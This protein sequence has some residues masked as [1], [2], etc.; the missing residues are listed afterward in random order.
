MEP[1]QNTNM[2][3]TTSASIVASVPTESSTS[4]STPN[5]LAESS[6]S[7][8]DIVF[9]DKPKKSHGML[10]GMVLLAILAIGGIG[11]GVWEMMDGNSQVAKKDEQIAD[12]RGQLAEKNQ[13]VVEDNTTVV[14]V[15]TGDNAEASINTADYIYV[16]EW[17]LKIKIPEGLRNK[18]D[19]SFSNGD[20]LEITDYSGNY[21]YGQEI[22][23]NT[24]SL[25]K[26][27]RSVTG[28]IDFENCKT[29]CSKLITTLDG[30]DYAY[31]MTGNNLELLQGTLLNEMTKAEAFSK[32]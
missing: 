24:A 20:Y 30:Y 22:D 16:G 4:S 31:I 27:S 7:G 6:K 32:F 17:G 1:N 9:R 12:L 21:T 10:Y 11:F 3:S 2:Q 13:T 8:D 23:W 26:I 5:K 14:D 25:L 19:Y 28:T 18:I 29:S 15:E